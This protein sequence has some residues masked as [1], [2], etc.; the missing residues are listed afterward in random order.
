M[1][2]KYQDAVQFEHLGNNIIID[3]VTITTHHYF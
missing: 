2:D 3:A 1:E